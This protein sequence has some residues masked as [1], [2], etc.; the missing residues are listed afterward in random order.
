MTWL[1]GYALAGA[2]IGFVAGMLGVGGGMMLV[3]IMVALFGAQ[4]FVAGHLVHLAL[5]TAMASIV[6][7]SGASVREHH[8]LGAV[9]WAIVKRMTP[10]MITGTLVA[11]AASGLVPQRELALAFAVIV[12]CAAIQMFF[13]KKPKAER[14]LPGPVPL[15]LVG[16][17]IGVIAG[18]VS[19]GGAFV[20]MP[21]MM[22]CGVRAIVAIGTAAA[23]SV[24]VAV[25]GTI[26]Y[27]IAG[28]NVAGLPPYSVGF[29]YL[30][31]LAAIVCTSV[32]T[33]PFGA[34]LAHRL[35]V[36][37]LKRCFAVLLLCLAARMLYSFW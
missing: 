12:I 33:A 19:A 14:T 18:L 28:W 11:T 15:F 8:K 2:L 24:P 6:F 26:G 21:F 4:G 31:A 25:M 16:T 37:V 36:Q 20:A 32:L 3:P 9:D 30:P 13:G 5:G 35:P 1:A 10:G 7:T 17:A 29:I 27:A 22:F 23:L 34:R